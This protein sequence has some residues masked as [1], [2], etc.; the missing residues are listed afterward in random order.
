MSIFSEHILYK[1]RLYGELT[2]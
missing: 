2:V 1:T